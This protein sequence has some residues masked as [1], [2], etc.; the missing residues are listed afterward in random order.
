MRNKLIAA[1][2][3]LF[4]YGVLWGWAIGADL[5]DNRAKDRVDTLTDVVDRQ[6]DRLEYMQDLLESIPM[7]E[8]ELD[9][10]SNSSLPIDE[11]PE[12]EPNVTEPAA[13]MG[14]TAEG[15]VA[16]SDADRIVERPIPPGETPAQ[17]E[18]NLRGLIERYVK[19]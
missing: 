16:Y 8:E 7:T 6:S 18:S 19:D 2:V 10:I 14:V 3:G 15:R 11:A 12:V 1:G 17:T 4:G 9:T 13:A 5:A